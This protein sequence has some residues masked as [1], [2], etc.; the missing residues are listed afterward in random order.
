F[1]A[2]YFRNLL[3][4]P[5]VEGGQAMDSYAQRVWKEDLGPTGLFNRGDHLG[6]YDSGHGFQMIDQAG[7][8]QVYALQN[9]PKDKLDKIS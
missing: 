6:G 2:I 3:Q 1:N 4:V 7:L 5:G 9:W 8:T